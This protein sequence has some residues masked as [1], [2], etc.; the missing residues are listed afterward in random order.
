MNNLEKKFKVLRSPRQLFKRLMWKTS[1]MWPER[2]YL[3]VLAWNNT[4][5][6]INLDNPKTY[7][8]KM[9]WLKL[10]YHKAIFTKMVDKYGVKEYVTERLGS[11]K[12]VIPAYGV[13][14]TFDDIDFEKLPNE[15]IMKCTHDSGSQIVCRDKVA[16]NKTK[17]RA[18]LE[19]GMKRDYFWH[20]R[21]WPYKNV[22][23]KILIEKFVPQ[24]GN[25]E[26][27]EYKVTCCDGKVK[28]I[29]V[30]TGPAHEEPERRHNDHFD[31]EWNRI[32]FEVVFSKSPYPIKKPSMLKELIEMS[33][34]L[35]EGL[36][37]LRVDWYDVDGDILFGEL[38]FYTWGGACVFKPW[39][40]NE[41]L[42]SW[43][44]LP[45]PCLEK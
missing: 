24:L 1:K 30:C 8:D 12:Y 5:K 10:Y 20:N 29:T 39:S 28:F 37:Y 42:G 33:E 27:I 3:K 14:N 40:F 31:T 17:A 41:V 32:N 45:E 4:G 13:Y 21:E 9:S 26:S 18:I 34:K 2:A 6:G 11:D 23:R 16:F 7:N 19:K 25:D 43:I 38:T 15:F 35:A 36:P 44:T 22:P